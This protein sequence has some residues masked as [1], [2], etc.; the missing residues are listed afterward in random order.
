MAAASPE[1]FAWRAWR[2]ENIV[3][4]AKKHGSTKFA[5]VMKYRTSATHAV[6]KYAKKPFSSHEPSYAKL[7][8]SKE[9]AL[10]LEN[11]Q[12]FRDFVQCGFTH[13]GGSTSAPKRPHEDMEGGAQQE[14]PRLRGSAML[15]TMRRSQKRLPGASRRRTRAWP[16]SSR[17]GGRSWASR[18]AR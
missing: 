1:E 16:T 15:P 6:T 18:T 11:V 9:E 7:W 17:G 2:I 13:G 12:R 14:E 4:T 8:D 10:Q 5:L 3:T